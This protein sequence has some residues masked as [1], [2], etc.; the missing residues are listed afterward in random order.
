MVSLS[1][2][3]NRLGEKRDDAHHDEEQTDSIDL[4]PLSQ[5]ICDGKSLQKCTK[6]FNQKQH[7]KTYNCFTVS[8]K[9]QNEDFSFKVILDSKSLTAR[10]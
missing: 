9:H 10:I 7:L 6:R 3:L 8:L 1:L 2:Y 4:F 5:R